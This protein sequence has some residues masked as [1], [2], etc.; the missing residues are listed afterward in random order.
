MI[1]IYKDKDVN[2]MN[3]YM[4]SFDPVLNESNMGL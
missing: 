1:V 2:Q 4:L 3:F